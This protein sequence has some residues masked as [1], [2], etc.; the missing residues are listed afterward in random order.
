[1]PEGPNPLRR[2]KGKIIFFMMNQNH[3]SMNVVNTVLKAVNYKNDL[4]L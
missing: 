1:M 3:Q 4:T 2:G